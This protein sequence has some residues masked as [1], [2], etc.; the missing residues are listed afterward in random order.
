VG[1]RS[2]SEILKDLTL[3]ELKK[4]HQR[5][6]GVAR[7][8]RDRDLVG[9]EIN[10]T[11]IELYEEPCVTI[12]FISAIGG[13]RPRQIESLKR[14]SEREKNRPATSVPNSFINDDDS[15]DE[16]EISFV[17]PTTPKKPIAPPSNK[18]MRGRGPNKPLSRNDRASSSWAGGNPNRIVEVK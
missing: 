2:K 14:I 18:N 4:V 5:P 13:L 8:Y 15:D 9:K 10:D 17:E 16:W 11:L 1:G 6:C 3:F 7:L 12:D